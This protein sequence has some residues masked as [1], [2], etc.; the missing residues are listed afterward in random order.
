MG[1]NAKACRQAEAGAAIQRGLS[2]VGSH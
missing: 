2:R 1:D